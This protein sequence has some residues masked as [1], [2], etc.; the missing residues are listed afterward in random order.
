M[1]APRLTFLW[2]FL[3]KPA[4]IGPQRRAL[5]SAKRKAHSSAVR[6]QEAYPQ[7]YGTANEPIP[8]L[9]PPPPGATDKKSLE[10]KS[11]KLSV[12]QK[13]EKI[14]KD[15]DASSQPKEDDKAPVGPQDLTAAA[16][17][18]LSIDTPSPSTTSQS[19]SST[20]SSLSTSPSQS[21][22]PDPP[23]APS[24]LPLRQ[25]PTN[26]L[27]TVL[28]LPASEEHQ[29]AQI[30]TSYYHENATTEEKPPHIT[31]PRY[32]HHFDTYSLV[33]RLTDGGWTLPQA[34]TAMK[35]V[36]LILADN[37]GLAR[38]GLVSKSQVENE[39][40][41]FRAACSE[42][43]TEVGMRR[44]AETE[45]SR[46]ERTGL[47]HEV[48][49]LGQRVGMETQGLR[50]E[51]KG[52]VEGRKMAVREEGRGTDSKI[53]ELNY[54]ITVALN[55]DSRSDVEGVRWLITKRAIAALAICAMMVLG[56][57]RYASSVMQ[58][59]EEVRKR[60]RERQRREEMMERER[61]GGGGGGGGDGG[62]SLRE[63]VVA[64]GD[65]PSFVSLG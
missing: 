41:L 16:P 61:R 39:Q 43:R 11:D 57:L 7:R 55:S 3:F 65:N 40:Y 8:Q 9:Q 49:I 52:M 5:H 25:P 47:Q 32:V 63:M 19:T 53:Q 18:V 33:R 17:T 34:I 56:S 4:H 1:A 42:L 62:E 54:R 45:K 13:K 23:S 21:T 24:P 22:L 14:A 59:E 37:I 46:T 58:A 30:P 28:N 29:S 31:T 12:K 44:K 2:P 50:E 6:R 35:A 27:E 20:K 64:Q 10:T 60:E 48:D 26:P 36:R 51:L 38:S 15:K